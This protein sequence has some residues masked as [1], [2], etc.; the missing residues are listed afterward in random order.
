MSVSNLSTRDAQIVFNIL[1]KAWRS[2]PRGP[3]DREK[4]AYEIETTAPGGAE[5]AKQIRD[6]APLFSLLISILTLLLM[7]QS[8]RQQTDHNEEMLAAS[9]KLVEITTRDS[10]SLERIAGALET[11]NSQIRDLS[12]S[13]S[14][15]IELL[16]EATQ[17]E[18][19]D[20]ISLHKRLND[21]RRARRQ[22]MTK[23][24]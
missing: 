13:L 5:L 23:K 4:L 17:K 9:Q 6:G 2:P 22:H 24:K 15:Q 21:K 7:I 20:E 14:E 8:G 18:P 1:K 11:Q 3:S 10:S 19:D 16:Q 12:L